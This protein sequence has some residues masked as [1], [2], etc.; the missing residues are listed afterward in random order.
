MSRPDYYLW[1]HD[2]MI[3]QQLFFDAYPNLTGTYISFRNSLCPSRYDSSI[4]CFWEG[5]LEV[6]VKLN[7]K[8]ITINDHDFKRGNR[9]IVDNYII[10]GLAAVV[11]NRSRDETYLK[12]LIRQV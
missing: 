3:G 4:R 10:Q 8:E 5:D 12:F 7:G 9:S 6:V 1:A 2:E 11:E